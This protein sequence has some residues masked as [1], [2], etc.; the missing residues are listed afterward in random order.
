[1]S[2]MLPRPV[3]NFQASNALSERLPHVARA[4]ETLALQVAQAEPNPPQDRPPDLVEEAQVQ[5][6]V[7]MLIQGAKD[8]GSSL[9]GSSVFLCYDKEDLPWA[10]ELR[11]DLHRP[12]R[13]PCF[14][15]PISIDPGKRWETKIRRALRQCKV[16]L[17]LATPTGITSKW[18]NWEVGAAW[19]LDKQIVPAL[20]QISEQQL[21]EVLRLF[22]WRWARTREEQETLIRYIKEICLG[23]TS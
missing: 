17:M 7:D 19:G 18:C 10:K 14:L 5:R 4:L 15:A 8:L 1:M 22:Q 16:L 6:A 2:E 13:V 20:R 9:S 3:L 12:P 11:R 21:P 23:E